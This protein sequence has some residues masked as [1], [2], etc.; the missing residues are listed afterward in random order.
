MWGRRDFLLTYGGK[1][2]I[3]FV[4]SYERFYAEIYKSEKRIIMTDAFEKFAKWMILNKETGYCRISPDAP[5]EIKEE[6]KKENEKHF[7]LTGRNFLE[8][9]Y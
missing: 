1:R 2:I 3:I 7:K 5:Q 4:E 8:I 9:D 6:A